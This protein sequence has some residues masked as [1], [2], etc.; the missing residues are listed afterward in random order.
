LGCS[1]VADNRIAAPEDDSGFPESVVL[2][3]SDN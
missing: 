1:S 2:G 3:W